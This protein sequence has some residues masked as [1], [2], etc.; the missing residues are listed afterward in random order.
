MC[1]YTCILLCSLAVTIYSHPLNFGTCT[2]TKFSRGG[3]TAHLD[4]LVWPTRP[5]PPSLI[6]YTKIQ[7]IITSLAGQPLA[8][9]LACQTTII[10]WRSGGHRGLAGKTKII[11]AARW[12][13][14]RFIISKPYNGHNVIKHWG[15]Q[16]CESIDYN[17]IYIWVVPL[18]LNT[19]AVSVRM[20]AMAQS[21]E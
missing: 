2:A 10:T 21:G 3:T 17:Y 18:V 1:T 16:P 20:L 5:T 4:T 14:E 19:L 9:G 12:D 13:S 6:H 7:T 15:Y 11:H 8:K